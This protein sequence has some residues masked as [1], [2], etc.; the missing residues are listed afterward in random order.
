MES[1]VVLRVVQLCVDWDGWV[2]G[3]GFSVVLM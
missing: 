3:G 1:D 2:G